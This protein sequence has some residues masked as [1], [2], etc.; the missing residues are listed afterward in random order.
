MDATGYNNAR[1]NEITDLITTETDI[2]KRTAL[3]DEAWTSEQK[4]LM[5]QFIS[6]S[7]LGYDFPKSMFDCL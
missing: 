5:Y 1:V 3:I 2:E 4:C 7:G 6:S